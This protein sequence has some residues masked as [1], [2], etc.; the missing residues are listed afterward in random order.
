GNHERRVGWLL[1]VR[2]ADD[3]ALV[4]PHHLDVHA[5]AIADVRGGGH[6]P[7]RMDAAAERRQETD[8]PV[9][10]LVEAALDDDGAV[11]RN[12]PGRGLAVQVSQEVLRR[13]AV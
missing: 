9:A 12:R 11:V 6:R 10:E 8:A 7:R 3:E 4:T 1:D 5:G 13:R 2:K